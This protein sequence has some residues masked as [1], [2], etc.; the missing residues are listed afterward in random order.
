MAKK[1]F[2][3]GFCGVRMKKREKIPGNSEGRERK[4]ALFREG[5]EEADHSAA[6]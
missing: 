5:F 2:T 6:D 3:S 4:N 1:I